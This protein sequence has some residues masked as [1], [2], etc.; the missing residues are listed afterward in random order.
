MDKRGLET[1]EKSAIDFQKKQIT[2]NDLQ[3]IIDEN[4]EREKRKQR[5]RLLKKAIK[6]PR[7]PKIKGKKLEK[8]ETI[9]E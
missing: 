8:L 3:K 6:N 5:E 4:T 9:K 2:L 1:P 7:N